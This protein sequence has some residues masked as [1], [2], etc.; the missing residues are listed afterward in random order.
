MTS[1]TTLVKYSSSISMT[2]NL[3]SSSKS[4]YRSRFSKVNFWSSGLSFFQIGW[5]KSGSR[6]TTLGLV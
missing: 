5:R 3:A 6:P 4:R 2:P 1:T